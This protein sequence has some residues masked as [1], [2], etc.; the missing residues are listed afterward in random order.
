MRPVELGA[1]EL[2]GRLVAGGQPFEVVGCNCYYLMTWAADPG[3]RCHVDE[4][5]DTAV[6][7]GLNTIRTWAFNDGA[8]QWNALQPRPGEHDARVLEALDY[9]V[10][11]AAR[12]GLRLILTLVNHWDDY[13]GRAQYA[14]W[15]PTARRPDDFYRDAYCRE[16][17]RDHA[18]TLVERTNTY[19]G[20]AYRD[21]PAIL[22]WELANEPR[23][24]LD[25]SGWTLQCWIDE[26][27][28]W[29]D[30]LTPNQLISVGV[31]GFWGRWRRRWNPPRWLDG[32]GA[33]FLWNHEPAAVDLMSFH[34]YPD[35][36]HMTE[37]ESARWVAD[38]LEA[39]ASLGKPVLMG[40]YGK[41]GPGPM[42]R[43]YFRRWLDQVHARPAGQAG[44][45][46]WSLYHDDYPDYDGFGVYRRDRATVE[47]LK[48]FSPSTRHRG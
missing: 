12:R 37:D 43:R 8:D 45:L 5:L 13:G 35:H 29:L 33:D 7:L 21:E 41:R 1:G 3:L 9:V 30:E 31:E 34:V 36:W 44:S 22:A 39:A 40:E 15:S 23:C 48:V 42:R 27:A 4:I 32:Q 20:R 17:Y 47:L 24:A 19:S 6:E 25:P 11:Q 16:L 10:W 46:F 26:M 38:H 28:A 14:R 18:C 2:A